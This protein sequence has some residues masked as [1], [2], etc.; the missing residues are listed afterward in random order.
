MI[1]KSCNTL[2][3]IKTEWLSDNKHFNKCC[4]EVIGSIPG[5]CITIFYS[6]LLF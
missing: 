2:C 3:T 5:I 1:I 4:L 6:I